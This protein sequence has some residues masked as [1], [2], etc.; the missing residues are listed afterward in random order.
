MEDMRRE[1]EEGLCRNLKCDKATVFNCDILI[2]FL[3]DK[4]AVEDSGLKFFS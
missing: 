3:N 4:V 1:E 2:F